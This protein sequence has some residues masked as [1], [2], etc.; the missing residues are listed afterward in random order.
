MTKISLFTVS[1]A[2]ALASA[3]CEKASGE[4]KS[5]ER[6]RPT[7]VDQAPLGAEPREAQPDN[8][9][10][11]ERDRDRDTA[12]PLPL[13]Q[14]NNEQDLAIT[15]EIRKAIV[16]DGTLSM[17]AKNVKVITSGRVV[18]LRGPVK[19]EAEKRSIEDKARATTN[20]DRVDDL[21]EV[22]TK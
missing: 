3:A 12:A 17:A 14:G 4:L 2:L 5:D 19:N 8:T 6:A 11:N 16:S 15:Q 20:V 18:T 22:E 7:T 1:C 9:K 13:D 21:L 10:R